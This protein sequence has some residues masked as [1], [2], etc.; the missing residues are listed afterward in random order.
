MFIYIDI[1]M[2]NKEQM[3]HSYVF[4]TTLIILFTYHYSTRD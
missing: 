3:T 2:S 4:I 1:I